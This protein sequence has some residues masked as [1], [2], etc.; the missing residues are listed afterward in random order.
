MTT[1][2]ECGARHPDPQTTCNDAFNTLLG[3]ETEDIERWAVHHLM[4]LSYHLQHPSIYSPE[5]LEGAIKLL[6]EFIETRIT[7]DEV[8]QREKDRLNSNRRRFKITA[9]EDTRGTYKHPVKWRTTIAD[10]VEPG[11]ENYNA[12]VKAWAMSIYNT[13]K[14][15]DN[16]VR[17][18]TAAT[19]KA[20]GPK[21]PTP[22]P[23]GRPKDRS[24][25]PQKPLGKHWKPGHKK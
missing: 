24:G 4:V 15:T 16:L 20:A 1:C 12:N 10:V 25:Q 18:P 14:A 21:G 2:P 13:L 22:K 3:W 7:P 11:P 19:S 6:A 8:R 17:N 9:T 5:G 23:T